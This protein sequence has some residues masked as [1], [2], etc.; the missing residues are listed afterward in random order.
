MNLLI[1][2]A[3]ICGMLQVQAFDFNPFSENT[4]IVYNDHGDAIIFDPG[5]YTAHDEQILSSFIEDNQ[6][7]PRY[8]IN[9]HCHIDHILGNT[10]VAEKYQL[11]LYAHKNE[12]PILEMGTAT[13]TMYGL[14]YYPSVKI[15][16]YIDENDTIVLGKDRLQILFTPGHSP[17]SLSFYNPEAG[18]VIAGDVL[19][20]RSIGR[21]DLP[22]GDHETLL[23]SIRTQLFTLPDKTI[24]Y[25]GHGPETYIGEEKQFNPFFR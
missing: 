25:S 15:V 22:G 10:Y 24:V 2:N 4:Y 21:S 6:L 14:H 17:G 18:F 9:T 3:V 1:K 11:E 8:L 20:N 13:A 7:T 23:Q 12:V 16:N 19:F 5:T